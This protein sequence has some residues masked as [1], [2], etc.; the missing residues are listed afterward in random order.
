[1]ATQYCSGWWQGCW[2]QSGYGFG[3]PD[4]D[5]TSG[6]HPGIDLGLPFGTPVYAAEQGTV[7]FAGWMAGLGNTIIMTLDGTQQIVFGHLS[8]IGVKR[9]D[10]AGAGMQIGLSG[11]SGNTTGNHLHF[12]VRSG[13]GIPADPVAWLKNHLDLRGYLGTAIGSQKTGDPTARGPLDV[14]GAISDAVTSIGKS[15]TQI[16]YMVLGLVLFIVGLW[17]TVKA[18]GGKLPVP[19]H[20]GTPLR[21]IKGA[22]EAVA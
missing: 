6:Q 2:T 9:G 3:S 20:V 14:P 22:K 8:H 19:A 7:V 16:A 15:L 21:V 12:E 11:N 1:M 4:P 10:V 17:L 5:Y 18:E 13:S